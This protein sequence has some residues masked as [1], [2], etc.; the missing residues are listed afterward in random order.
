[1]EWVKPFF[2]QASLWW[3]APQIRASD[4]ERV[5][6]MERLSAGRGGDAPLRV[7]DLGAGGGTTAAVAAA[8]GHEVTAVE[9][10]ATRAGF[11]RDRAQ[12]AEGRLIVVE[13]DFYQVDVGREFDCVCCWN[14]F[15]VGTDAEQRQLLRRVSAEWLAPGA[16]MV[17]TV[18]S[19]F[20]WARDAGVVE[21]DAEQPGLHNRRSYDPYASRF[22]DTW[23]REEDVAGA[24]TQEARCY[25]PA[26]MALLVE[27]TGLQ[28]SRCELDGSEL[29]PGGVYDETHPLWNAW[30]YL[31]QLEFSAR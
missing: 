27:G 16:V 23:W 24:V 4:H 2:D 10:S 9:L 11:L 31:V 15:G 20:R 29:E 17:L 21:L 25:T 1:M 6:V 12:H 14:G 30:E 7:L 19:P 28:I 13:G 22:R 18:F 3:G 26:D 8:R 5:A